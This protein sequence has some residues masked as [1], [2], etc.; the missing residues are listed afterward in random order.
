MHQ[1]SHFTLYFLTNLT[2]Y[3]VNKLYAKL[4]LKS[5]QNPALNANSLHFYESLWK[6]FFG[7]ENPKNVFWKGRRSRPKMSI[8]MESSHFLWNPMIAQ[9]K[10]KGAHFKKNFV[11]LSWPIDIWYNFSWGFQKYNFFSSLDTPNRRTTSAHAAHVRAWLQATWAELVRWLSVSNFEKNYIFVILM[12][13]CTKYQS[14]IKIR[15]VAG[16]PNVR[17]FTAFWIFSTLISRFVVS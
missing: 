10:A 13:N 7:M 2:K 14:A 9:K 3:K 17:K 8:F 12:K 11:R 4:W 16:T 6:A 1:N 5:N 15:D